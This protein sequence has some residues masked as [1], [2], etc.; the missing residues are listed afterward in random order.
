MSIL[1]PYGFEETHSDDWVNILTVCVWGSLASL[2]HSP[3]PFFVILSFIFPL[4]NKTQNNKK[5]EGEWV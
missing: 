4:G 2:T 1:A 5:G 3:S